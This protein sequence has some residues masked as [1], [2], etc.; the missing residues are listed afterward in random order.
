[1]SEARQLDADGRC[2]GRKPLAYK[3]RHS[4]FCQQCH[5]S[6]DIDTGRQ[7]ENWAWKPAGDGFERVLIG[8]ER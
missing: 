5:R 1:V 8:A 7:I 6:Y 2:C 3:R 4:R